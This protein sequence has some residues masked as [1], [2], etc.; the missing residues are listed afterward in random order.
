[1]ERVGFSQARGEGADLPLLH[2][3]GAQKVAMLPSSPSGNGPAE[4]LDQTKL[5][6]FT[7]SQWKCLADQRGSLDVLGW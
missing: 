2:S 6:S 1:M 4:T 3:A 5:A 7:N